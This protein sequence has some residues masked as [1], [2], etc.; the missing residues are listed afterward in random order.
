MEISFKIAAVTAAMTLLLCSCGS[1]SSDVTSSELLKAA[2]DSGASFEEMVDVEDTDIK[3]LYN[4]EKDWYDEFSASAAG[5]LAFA[6]EI[7]VVKSSSSDNTDKIKNA[8][9]QRVESRK[10]TL[11]SYAPDEYS[12][13]CESEIKTSGDFIYLIVGKDNKKAEKALK[14]LL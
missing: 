2:S 3:Y 1:S 7:V 14:K 5:N 4:I 6:D 13:L 9:E 11:Q 12:K 8:L 10:K